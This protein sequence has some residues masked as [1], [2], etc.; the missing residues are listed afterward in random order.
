MMGIKPGSLC[1][2]STLPIV[3]SSKLHTFVVDWNFMVYNTEFI[4]AF[5]IHNSNNE[6]KL[7]FS[8]LSQLFNSW[9][10]KG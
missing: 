1:K 8:T 6:E 3:L 10:Q 9:I 2:V 4:L 7:Y 5:N